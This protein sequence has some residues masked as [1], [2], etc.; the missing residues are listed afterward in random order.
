MGKGFVLKN[1]LCSAFDIFRGGW[2]GL[3]EKI[4]NIFFC[5]I[6]NMNASPLAKMIKQNKALKEPK[7][8]AL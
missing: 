6:V 1:F 8:K 5:G 3:E 2:L 7:T 4:K